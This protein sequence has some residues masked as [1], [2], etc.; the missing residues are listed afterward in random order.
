[1]RKFVLIKICLCFNLFVGR[2]LNVKFEEN[3]KFYPRRHTTLDHHSLFHIK[4]T[5][6][7][8]MKTL[9]KTRS[10]GLVYFAK[11]FTTSVLSHLR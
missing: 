5:A 9:L 8:K 1:M 4:F 2:N 7:C 6:R 10:F 3:N 11:E